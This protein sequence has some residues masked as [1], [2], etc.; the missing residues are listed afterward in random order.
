MWGKPHGAPRAAAGS[1][2]TVLLGVG[3]DVTG[4]PY[5]VLVEGVHRDVVPLERLNAIC[6]GE[7]RGV[8]GLWLPKAPGCPAPACLPCAVP[9]EWIQRK[10]GGCGVGLGQ[11]LVLGHS[12]GVPAPWYTPPA[13][14]PRRTGTPSSPRLTPDEGCGGSSV[15]LHLPA[16]AA[17]AGLRGHPLPLQDVGGCWGRWCLPAYPE[18]ALTPGHG[19]EPG[20]GLTCMGTTSRDDGRG[21]HP[22]CIAPLCPPASAQA[23]ALPLALA[24][25]PVGSLLGSPPVTHPGRCLPCGGVREQHP[26]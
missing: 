12:G 9:Q 21:E 25:H 3:C 10:E 26:V 16:G 5:G 2:R 4:H 6:N 18:A 15:T 19:P 17:A 14:P 7:E 11:R 13:Q 23:P 1:T 24:V 22:Y 8:L 20:Q